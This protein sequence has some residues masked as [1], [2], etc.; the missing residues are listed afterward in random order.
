MTITLTIGKLRGLQ[1]CSTQRGAM[2]ILALDHRNNLRQLIRPDSPDQ[3]TDGEMVAFK[4]Q[5]VKTLAPISSA[6]L[7]DPEVGAAQ[8]ISSHILPG[9]TGLIVAVD[10]TGYTGEPSA[11][12]SRLLPGWSV[13]K[14]RRMGASAVKLLVYYHPES[15][16]AS[17]VEALVR[18][19]SKDCMTQDIPLFLEP[20]S[21]SLD[22][23]RKKLPPDE[24]R[25]VVIETARRLTTLGVDI[26]KA[27]FPIDINAHS[28]ENRWADACVELTK[29]SH[30]PW[31]LLSASADFDTYLQQVTVACRAGASG[32]AVGRSVWQEAAGL[33]GDVRQKFLEDIARQRMARITALCDALARPWMEFYTSPDIDA[34]WYESY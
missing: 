18:E 16:T 7:L 8:C 33:V 4:Q 23:E 19:V 30:V 13:A 5:V 10:A 6:V 20:L 28:D 17:Q 2:A 9:T 14:A 26:L 3:V 1:Q 12:Q 29:T 27:E 25:H 22:P 15:P 31:V 24:R 34:K 32:V 11:R 21:Y